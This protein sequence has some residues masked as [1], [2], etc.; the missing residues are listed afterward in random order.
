MSA[1][2]DK[3]KEIQARKAGKA[4]PAPK[5]GTTPKA[6]AGEDEPIPLKEGDE[7]IVEDKGYNVYTKQPFS[8]R[9]FL[10]S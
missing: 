10:V 3:L 5:K 7:P 1:A 8:M 6:K 9:T 4:L 2:L